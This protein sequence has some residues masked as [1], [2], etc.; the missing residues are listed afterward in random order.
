MSG[1]A[2]LEFATLVAVGFTACA[3]FGSFLFVHPVIRALPPRHQVAFEKGLLTTFGRAMPLLM[4]VAPI[5]LGSR[6]AQLDG[7]GRVLA[8]M[9][10][11]ATALALL[12]TLAINVGINR[13]TGH[14]DPDNPPADW[15]A[16]RRRWDRGQGVRASLLLVGF[17]LLAAASAA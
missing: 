14:W 2:L 16:T 17:V 7:A 5:L 9:A 4:T 6:A 15:V 8:L 10:L 12:S 3:E 11:V 1:F 13:A